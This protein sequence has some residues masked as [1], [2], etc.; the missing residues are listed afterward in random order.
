MTIDMPPSRFIDFSATED[1]KPGDIIRITYREDSLMLLKYLVEL[2]NAGIVTAFQATQLKIVMRF[3]RWFEPQNQIFT[4]RATDTFDAKYFY[5][6]LARH[7]ERLEIMPRLVPSMTEVLLKA[8]GDAPAYFRINDNSR[9]DTKQTLLNFHYLG[10]IKLDH[11][12]LLERDITHPTDEPCYLAG[13][14][15][16]TVLA[17]SLRG[18]FSSIFDR[19]ILPHLTY[20]FV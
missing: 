16:T 10:V 13:Q 6:C 7:I 9:A 15:T 19:D 14:F 1:V 5:S 11:P 8:R 2:I 17:Q 12:E 4:L 18:V 3:E 20:L